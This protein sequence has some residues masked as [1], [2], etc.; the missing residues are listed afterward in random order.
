LPDNGQFLQRNLPI[1]AIRSL[2]ACSTRSDGGG[3]KTAVWILH[4]SLALEAPGSL[5]LGLS[6][7]ITDNSNRQEVGNGPA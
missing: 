2:R 5:R 6:I 3:D 1:L 4:L 7:I